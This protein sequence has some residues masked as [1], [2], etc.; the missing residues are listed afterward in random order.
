MV[1][2]VSVS[3]ISFHLAKVGDL[4]SIKKN[5]PRA[6]EFRGNKL[7][8]ATDSLLV[9]KGIT[10]IGMVPTEFLKSNPCR[11]LRKAKIVAL[12]QIKNLIAIE[13]RIENESDLANF[14]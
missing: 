10:K 4:V 8:I 7:G 12:D 3:P 9:F 2:L 13:M 5:K 14:D 11:F 1:Y 6:N